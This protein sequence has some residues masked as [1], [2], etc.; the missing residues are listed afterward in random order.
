[1]TLRLPPFRSREVKTILLVEK[2]HATARPAL[3]RPALTRSTLALPVLTLIVIG[4]TAPA[5]ARAQ[6]P[7]PQSAPT[8]P[9]QSQQAPAQPATDPNAAQ[10]LPATTSPSATQTPAPASTQTPGYSVS[11]VP[12]AAQT[13]QTTHAT[14][15]GPAPSGSDAILEAELRTLLVGKPLFL[16]GCYL[17]DDL[18]FNER[19]GLYD[20]SPRGSFTL[21]GIQIENLRL[22]KKELILEGDRYGYRFLG[23]LPGN[24]PTD[25]MERIK[26]TPK[27]KLLR[28]RIER[29]EVVAPKKEKPESAKAA[30]T[31]AAA[32]PKPPANAQAASAP[33]AA[34]TSAATDAASA[35]GTAAVPSAASTPDAATVSQA[36]STPAGAASATTDSAAVDSVKSGTLKDEPKTT[37][38]EHAV[39]RLKDTLARLFTPSLDDRF[40]AS[41]PDFWQLYYKNLTAKT[42]FKPSDSTVLRQSQVDKKAHLVSAIDPPSNTYAQD[43]GVAGMAVYH[44]VV[45]PDGRPGEIAVGQPI[46][47]GLDEN[48]VDT[49]KK[50]TFEPA[51]KDGKPVPVELDLIVQFHIYS[52]L[53]SGTSKPDQDTKPALPGPYSLPPKP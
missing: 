21:S 10:Q 42:E 19:G 29:E 46:G 27:K 3:T 2:L 28:I 34:T 6:D 17:S 13:A 32:A 8:Q 51:I 33:A 47:F 22:T 53:T 9:A 4:L 50:A 49:L 16:R 23:A 37:S 24:N 40:V 15:M 41:M 52:K 45:G 14:S 12:P 25:D 7:A 31:A 30:K 20:S 43:Y 35:S 48:A 39:Q 26:I 38:P 11:V 1:M 5:P 18:R 44:V 36:P